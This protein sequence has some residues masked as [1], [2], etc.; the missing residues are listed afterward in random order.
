[1]AWQLVL[2]GAHL[3]EKKKEKIFFTSYF[4]SNKFNKF[5]IL[6]VIGVN[7]LNVDS[8]MGRDI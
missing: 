7:C 2:S 5:T 6:S 1:M 3:L 4:Q 8:F